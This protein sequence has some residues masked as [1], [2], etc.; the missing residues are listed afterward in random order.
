M[1]YLF[2]EADGVFVR[3]VKKKQSLEVHHAIFYEGWETNGQRISLKNPKV[4]M[5]TEPIQKFWDEV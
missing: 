1:D 3:G 4:I 2:V 5:T